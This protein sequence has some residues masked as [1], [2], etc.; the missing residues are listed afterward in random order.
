MRD[1]LDRVDVREELPVDRNDTPQPIREHALDQSGAPLR[2]RPIRSM[3][4]DA[5]SPLAPLRGRAKPDLAMAFGVPVGDTG[6]VIF[7]AVVT[8]TTAGEL[9]TAIGNAAAGDEIVLADGNYALAANV[10]CNAMG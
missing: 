8:V 4:I 10:S 2:H 7:A 9:T 6:I 1:Q 5:A 3:P